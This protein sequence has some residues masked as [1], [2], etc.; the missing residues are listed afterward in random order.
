MGRLTSTVVVVTGASA[1][2]GAATVRG[3]AAEGARV[4][5]CARRAERLDALVGEIRARGGNALAV[6]GDVTRE[7]DMQAVV[8]RTVHT[9]GRL[10][11]MVCNAGIGYHGPLDET[12]PDV[13][14]RLVD[15]NVLGTMY[16]ARAA[17]GVMRPRQAGHIIA[18]SSIAGRRGVGGSSVYS[19]TKAAQIGFIEA[20]RA[21]FE[22][23]AL[24]ASLVYPVSTTTEFHAAI[25]RD[26]GHEVRGRGPKQSADV[27][28]RAIVNCIVSPRAEVYPYW[29][30]WLLAVLA[31]VAPRQAD[32]LVRR[33]GRHRQSHRADGVDH[34]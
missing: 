3:V 29:P 28:A 14:R 24:R 33:F 30:A 2:I 13:M 20:L 10:D 21:E 19:A 32:R 34:A 18:V 22:G 15:V 25:A 16:A 31:V 7:D 5:A 27:V 26:F 17:L 9:Y 4:V 11:V 1:G 8:D 12:P 23:T 6:P